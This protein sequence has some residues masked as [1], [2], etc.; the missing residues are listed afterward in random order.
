[1]PIDF[2]GDWCSQDDSGSYVLPRRLGEDERCVGIL[3]ID[4]FGFNFLSMG[5][6]C[7]PV[8]VRTKDDHA[9]SGTTYDA[10]IT[11]RCHRDGPVGKG[12]LETYWFSVYKGQ[13]SIND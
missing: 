3:S 7:Y 6:Y 8:S 10:T 9:P 5:F 4:K 2:V 1:M 12:T 13:L 11:A